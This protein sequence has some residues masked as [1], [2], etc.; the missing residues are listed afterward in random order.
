MTST[1]TLTQIRDQIST[2][3]L[4]LRRR[5]LARAV[6]RM[7]M[8][9]L[10]SQHDVEMPIL[11]DEHATTHQL[12]QYATPAKARRQMQPVRTRRY[13]KWQQSQQ[14]PE[15]TRKRQKRLWQCERTRDRSSD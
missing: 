5:L 1:M 11:L 4:Q 13:R 8:R 6:A 12:Y 15:L 3:T 14:Q 10:T 9:A 2:S 7:L